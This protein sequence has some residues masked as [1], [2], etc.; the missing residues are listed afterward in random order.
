MGYHYINSILRNTTFYDNMDGIVIIAQH[1]RTRV[2]N[3]VFR[4]NG[5]IAISFDDEDD[6]EMENSHIENHVIG[7]SGTL[8]KAVLHNNTFLAN[9]LAFDASGESLEISGNIFKSNDKAVRLG[10]EN[11]VIINNKFQLNEV[12]LS[13]SGTNV[14][15]SGNEFQYNDKA[16]SLA[17][18][19]LLFDRNI[20]HHNGQAIDFSGIYSIYGNFTNNLIYEN[21]SATLPVISLGNS[22]VNLTNNTLVENSG[23]DG[24]L[25]EIKNSDLAMTNC[26]LWNENDGESD[27]FISV[28]SQDNDQK[29]LIV[30]SLISNPDLLENLDYY[31]D[32]IDADPAFVDPGNYDF[33]L[34]NSSP[35][36][37]A[38]LTDTLAVF[39]PETDLEGNPRISDLFADIGAY[40]FTS[41]DILILEQP[42]SKITCTDIPAY[43]STNAAGGVTAYQW[44]HNGLTIPQVTDRF[45]SVTHINAETAGTYNC[46]IAFGDSIVSTDTARLVKLLAPR[47]MIEE[48]AFDKCGL[49]DTM[50]TTSVIPEEFL[51]Y[52]WYLN[53]LPI[54]G[55]QGNTL[56]LSF[57]QEGFKG[58]YQVKAENM[59]G[60]DSSEKI[61]IRI[62][63]KPIVELNGPYYICD[64]DFQFLSPG[65]NFEYYRWSDGSDEWVLLATETGT[66]SVTVSNEN[67]CLGQ[68][69]ATVNVLSPPHVSLGGD[70]SIYINDMLMLDAGSG[71]DSYDW[72]TG[73]NGQVIEVEHS[74]PGTY[75]YWVSVEDEN[76]CIG[77]DSISVTVDRNTLIPYS[78]FGTLLRIYPNPSQG[79]LYLVPSEMFTGDIY[80]E[81]RKLN[82][83]LVY[84]EELS[85]LNP[86]S[87]VELS[88]LHLLPGPYLLLL[89]KLPYGKL[90]LLPD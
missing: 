66:Y 37:N 23:G 60:I 72:N 2:Q 26:I 84:Q 14:E 57:S 49:S 65:N 1:T 88:L 8:G 77:V 63:P 83:E 81:I 80:L 64:G 43:L 7:I 5:N 35:C 32:I 73:F 78:P 18:E 19:N 85:G 44:Q 22:H 86:E 54:A 50:L 58:M 3:C 46:L 30:N 13:L 68:D 27:L 56:D 75:T 25:I 9:K 31:S 61:F 48:A 24:T 87:S 40:E 12:A 74:E 41:G 47:I 76:S 53:N 33:H 34:S 6:F 71:F 11:V 79:I 17:I 70:T 62:F 89:N 90:I 29:V 42:V 59:C 45:L 16:V 10:G 4:S 67:G 38:G 28:Q 21:A 51:E 15:I 52:Q 82:G 39:Y 55:A 69:S 36:I 20:L